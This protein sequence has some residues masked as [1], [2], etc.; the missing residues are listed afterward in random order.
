MDGNE[1]HIMTT[2]QSVWIDT[3]LLEK[4]RRRMRILG[5]SSFGAYCNELIRRDLAAQDKRMDG[6]LGKH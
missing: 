1:S 3:D 6:N 4:A 2:K 5:F